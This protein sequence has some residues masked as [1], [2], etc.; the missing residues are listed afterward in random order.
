V[1]NKVALLVAL[2]AILVPW[3]VASA[4]TVLP[5]DAAPPAQQ[6]LRLPNTG[7]E[8]PYLDEDLTI[9]NRQDGTDLIQEPLVVYDAITG[10][11]HPVA[12]QSWFVSSDK[13]TWT[14]K[15]RKGL[16]W[17]DGVP[18]TAKDFAFMFRNQASPKTA[19]DFTYWTETVQGIKNWAAVN[20]GK[21]PLS[22]LGVSAPDDD[23]LKITTDAPRPYL[24]NAMVYAWAEPAH[25]VSKYG[26]T[27]ATSLTHMVFSGPYMARSWQKGVAI[28]FVPNPTYRGVRKA[29]FSKITW[30]IAPGNALAQFQTGQVD[31]TPYLSSGELQFALHTL[32]K[33]VVH[34]RS[35]DV[36]YLT[37]N[38]Y[39]KPFDDLRVRRAFNWALD[40]QTLA[41][42]VLKTIARPNDT[43]LMPGFPGYDRSI[44]VPYDVKKAQQALAAAGYPGGKGFPHVDI[45]VRNSPGEV[46]FTKPAAE[47]IQS[48]LKTNLG[49]GVGVKVIDQKVF[50]DMINKHQQPLFFV[51][52]NFDYVDPSDFMDLLVSGGRHAWSYKPY[53]QTVAAADHSFDPK[54]RLALY[55]KAQHILADQVPASF[56]F[57]PQY[58][59]L[60]NPKIANPP[61][62]PELT[63]DWMLTCYVKK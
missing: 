35:F 1:N 19:Y 44:T 49:I 25:V 22:A 27:W 55:A 13:L 40:R 18:L 15:I 53:N 63:D 46:P 20:A 56:L 3:Q 9:Y 14:F 45:Y 36:W 54:Q 58:S 26:N 29:P 47:Y 21:R 62:V 51:G 10:K 41:N 57:V 32:P 7:P 59:F 30:A 24:P 42:D 8:G 6:I 61:T 37:Y 11:I 50:T 48:Q 28:T 17:S 16:V 38:T 33:D 52:Y 34:A 39:T 12:A 5:P 31:E 43:L 23:T 4:G 2:V 60:W